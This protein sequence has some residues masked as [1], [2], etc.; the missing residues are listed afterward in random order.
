MRIHIEMPAWLSRFK[1]I[2]GRTPG[3]LAA[4][5]VLIAGGSGFAYYRLVYLPGQATEEPDVQT[6]VVRQG[7]LVIYASGTGTLM[8]S[9]EVNLSFETSG[10][11]TG[12]FVEVGQQVKAGDLLAQVDDSDSQIAYAQARRNLAE[13]TSPVA[14]ANA[15]QAIAQAE[16]DLANANSTLGFLISPIVLRRE[17]ELKKAEQVLSKAQAAVE[18]S[19]SDGEM[20]E[21][22]EKAQTDLERA[23][24]TGKR[25]GLL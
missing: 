20:Q 15:Q 14:L 8:A 25:T 1:K 11:V 7:D 12:I 4:A 24:S 22:L 23:R 10:Q 13:L 17:A 6:A 2:S 5:L 19:P 9:K 18:A 3:L 16:I 21:A